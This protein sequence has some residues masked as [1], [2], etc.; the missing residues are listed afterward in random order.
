MLYDK[1]SL[2][3]FPKRDEVFESCLM[4]NE[5]YLLKRYGKKLVRDGNIYYW[6]DMEYETPEKMLS[7]ESLKYKQ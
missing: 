6:L 2:D 3:S 4:F 1:G 7:K 5:D